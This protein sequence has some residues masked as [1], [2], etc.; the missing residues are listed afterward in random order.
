MK[1]KETEETKPRLLVPNGQYEEAVAKFDRLRDAVRRLYYSAHWTPDR[2]LTKTEFGSNDDVNWS[3]E[4][5]VDACEIWTDVRDAAGFPKGGSP[6]E[7]PFDGIRA[8]YPTRRLRLLAALVTKSKG[9]NFGTEET[10]AFLLLHS[11]E[12]RDRIDKTVRDFLS[13]KLA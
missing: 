9:Q 2:P 13:E 11:A 8:E 12:L 6:K 10:N 7:Q 3:K 1:A 5:A 4:V